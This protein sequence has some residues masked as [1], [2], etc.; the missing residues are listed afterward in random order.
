MLTV[1]LHALFVR[2][3]IKTVSSDSCSRYYWVR[4]GMPA[5]VTVN[6]H[7]GNIHRFANCRNS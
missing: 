4:D 1:K 7:Y 6:N 2:Q 3:Q 5:T